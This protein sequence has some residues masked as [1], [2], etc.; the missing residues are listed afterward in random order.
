MSAIK[1]T[2]IDHALELTS[3]LN[4]AMVKLCKPDGATMVL[5][6]SVR[7]MITKYRTL[8]EMDMNESGA[9]FYLNDFDDSS[10]EELDYVTKE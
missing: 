5:D 10:M 9:Y 3:T 6:S 1:V 7:A 4:A 8:F 2:T